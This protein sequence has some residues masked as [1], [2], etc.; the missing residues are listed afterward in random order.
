MK[1]VLSLILLLLMGGCAGT[2]WNRN[3]YEGIRQ[4]QKAGDGTGD[5]KPKPAMPD[6]DQYQRER[7]TLRGSQPEKRA[8]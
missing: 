4:Q 1:I 2:D 6:Y 8:D 5:V 7:A 3:I